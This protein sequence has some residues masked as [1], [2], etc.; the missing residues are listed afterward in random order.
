MQASYISIRVGLTGKLGRQRKAAPA[1]EQNGKDHP[2]YADYAAPID[3]RC[4]IGFA[5]L[6]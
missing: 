3:G 2:D 6:P 4:E 1:D 5:P